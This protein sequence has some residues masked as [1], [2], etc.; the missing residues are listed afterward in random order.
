MPFDRRAVAGRLHVELAAIEADVGSEELGQDR[1][2]LGIARQR[3]EEGVALEDGGFQPAHPRQAGAVAG[4]EVVEIVAGAN[5]TR[6]GDDAVGER[7]QLGELL[8]LDQAR[9]HQI[10]VAPIGLDLL[11]GQHAKP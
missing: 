7:A 1:G 10:P 11:V 8:A 9:D 6:L 4:L 2:D 5:A 3:L